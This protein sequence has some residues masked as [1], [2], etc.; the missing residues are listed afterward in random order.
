MSPAF[1]VRQLVATE[2]QKKS[3]G[4]LESIPELKAT[5][6]ALAKAFAN[7]LF[8]ATVNGKKEVGG[9]TTYVGPFWT[10]TVLCGLLGGEVY[11]AETTDD[12]K[13][14]VGCAVWFPPNHSMYDTEDQQEFV[15]GPLMGSFSEELGEW[16]EKKVDSYSENKYRAYMRR[17]FL[18]QYDAFTDATLG[19]GTKHESWH[20]Q[21][22]GIDPAYQRKGAATQLIDVVYRK[23]AAQG[24]ALVLECE[25]EFNIDVYT[26]L[27]F[28]LVLPKAKEGV[29]ENPTR[30]DYQD[31][32]VGV[33]GH[34]EFP[35]W[36]MRRGP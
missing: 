23:T 7:D 6:D 10:T 34:L 30:R 2:D 27:K 22:L 29:I 24:Q 36:V 25:E 17:Q 13:K 18:P 9:D 32:F 5:E 3:R 1:T 35:M 8:T 31:T 12:E 33:N 16:W 15:L 21:T 20:L 26:A 19:P 11:V 28:N 4:A 14:I